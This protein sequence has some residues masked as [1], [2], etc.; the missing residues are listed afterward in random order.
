MQ[1]NI[2]YFNNQM[3]VGE[4]SNFYVEVVDGSRE[5]TL[6]ADGEVGEMAEYCTINVTPI[7]LDMTNR[8]LTFKLTGEN[9]VYEGSLEKSIIGI[10]Y[11]A[12]VEEPQKLGTLKNVTIALGEQKFEYN[13]SSIN[14]NGIDYKKAVESVYN[15]CAEDL[16]SMFDG[17]TFKSE[18]YIKISCDRSKNPKEYFW[19]VNVVENSDNMF[20]VLIDMQTGEVIAKKHR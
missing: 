16:E 11:N 2:S 3:L 5:K 4:D 20:C 19:F 18:V 10:N 17:N 15:N 6:I 9:G 14:A 12:N 7:N 8:V 13:L 1:N